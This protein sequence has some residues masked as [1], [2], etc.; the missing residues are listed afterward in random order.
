MH[1]LLN[2]VLGLVDFRADRFLRP[3]ARGEAAEP[4]AEEGTGSR[5]RASCVNCSIENVSP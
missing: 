3:G 1:S 5:A 2:V 4:R